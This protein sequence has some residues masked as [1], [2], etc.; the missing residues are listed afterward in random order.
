M[1]RAAGLIAAF[2]ASALGGL[3]VFAPL[4]AALEWAGAEQ[5]GL[6]ADAV[7]GTVWSGSLRGARLRGFP[8]GD[9]EARLSPIA[10]LGGRARLSLMSE[11]GSAVLVRGR[12][13]VGVQDASLALGLDRLGLDLPWPGAVTVSNAEAVFEDGVC[14]AASGQVSTDLVQRGWGGPI[15][16]GPIACED[17]RAVAH[18]SGAGAGVTVQADILVAADG[19]Y[20]LQSRVEASDPAVESA[21]ALAGFERTEEGLVRTDSGFLGG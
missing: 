20:V 4:G 15:L 16:A 14:V 1:M 10:M 6:S 18:L 7:E 5:T 3:V 2:I 13:T 17:G 21:V 9:V 19:A 11:A 12:R 8:L